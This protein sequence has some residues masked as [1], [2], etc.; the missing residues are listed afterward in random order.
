[1]YICPIENVVGA[2]WG[3]EG[4]GQTRSERREGFDISWARLDYTGA[5]RSYIWCTCNKVYRELI[6]ITISVAIIYG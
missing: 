3:G 2:G 1:M 5:R 4:R 6:V